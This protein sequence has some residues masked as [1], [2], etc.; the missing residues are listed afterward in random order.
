M[1]GRH[2]QRGEERVIRMQQVKLFKGVEAELSS[3]ESEINNWIRESGARVVS[4]TGNIA[5]QSGNPTVG[6]R[7]QYIPSDVVVIVLYEP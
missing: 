6:G 1:S 7:T 4:V 3:L 2:R 5:P